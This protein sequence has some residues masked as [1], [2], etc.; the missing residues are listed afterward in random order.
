MTF[1]NGLGGFGDFFGYPRLRWGIRSL[2]WMDSFQVVFM[3]VFVLVLLFF[4]KAILKGLF[5]W[6]K[7]NNSPLLTVDAKLVGKR[8]SVH[9]NHTGGVN[10]HNNHH[11]HETTSYYVTFQV[12]SGDRMEFHVSGEEY[13]LLVEGDVG[14]LTFQGTRYT[15]FARKV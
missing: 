14:R 10:H 6:N 15:G 4:I 8:S 5:Q 12:E 1:L 3:I 11:H 9:H 2:I 7:N 13:G